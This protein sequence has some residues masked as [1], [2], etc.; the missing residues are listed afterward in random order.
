[1]VNWNIRRLSLDAGFVSLTQSVKK[2]S[3]RLLIDDWDVMCIQEPGLMTLPE[4]PHQQYKCNRKGGWGASIIVHE[5][6]ANR[7]TFNTHGTNWV[8]IGFDFSDL[9]WKGMI[10]C[11]HIFHP[12]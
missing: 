8:V 4:K 2:G 1:V 12:Q 6:F 7:V 11:P 3:D 9:G 5:R 10:L